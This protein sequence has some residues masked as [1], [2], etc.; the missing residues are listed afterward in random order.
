MKKALI[1]ML[2]ICMT[3]SSVGCA[4]QADTTEVIPNIEQEKALAETEDVS[5]NEETPD[6]SIAVTPKEMPANI[7]WNAGD[8][9]A[10]VFLGYGQ[11]LPE[12][13][14]EQALTAYAPDDMVSDISCYDMSGD[15]FYLIIP[16]Y[17]DTEINVYTY[18]FVDPT[19]ENSVEME[20]KDLLFSPESAIPFVYRANISDIFS[21]GLIELTLPDTTTSFSPCISLKDGTAL[22]NEFGQV[23]PL[24]QKGDSYEF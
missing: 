20:T 3:L 1:G 22:A 8:L 19:M 9:Y 15:E 2:T 10:L 6:T 18:D 5:T 16:K 4:K 17:K 13:E 7:Q 12:T 14:L 23:L 24:N 21:N 11:E